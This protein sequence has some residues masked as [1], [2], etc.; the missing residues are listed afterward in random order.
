MSH[1]FTF[2][3]DNRFNPTQIEVDADTVEDA[4]N[5]LQ[6]NIEHLILCDCD[7]CQVGND[8][9]SKFIGPYSS[10]CCRKVIYVQNDP[11]TNKFVFQKQP[12]EIDEEKTDNN[13]YFML[14]Q[15]SKEPIKI[16]PKRNIRMTSALDG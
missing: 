4:R 2:K 5:I 13:Q 6:D 8:S 16:T 12:N 10:R 15:I 14:G 7:V 9:V 1:T 3:I 11:I